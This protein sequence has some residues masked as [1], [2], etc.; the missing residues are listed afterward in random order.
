MEPWI[1]GKLLPLEVRMKKRAILGAV[2]MAIGCLTGASAQGTQPEWSR[3]EEETIRH[4]QALLRLDT[5]SPPGNESRAADYLKQVLESAGIPV[6]TFVL[7]PGRANLVARL[8]G[9]G[10]KRPLL[11]MAHTD[12]VTVDATKWTFPPFA[13]ARDG[14]YVYGRGALDDKDNLVASLMVMLLLKRQNVPLDRDVIFLAE[15]GEEGGSNVGINFMVERHFPEIDAEYC[16]AEGGDVRR[17]GGKL[18]FAGVQALEKHARTVELTARGLAGHASVPLETNPIAR[19]SAAV[20]AIAAWQAPIRLNEITSSYFR[21]LADISPPDRAAR[22]RAV[23]A[24]D[25]KEANAALGYFLKNEP[26]H[27]SILHTSV[28]PTII[29]GGYRVNVIP[30]EAKATL[31]VRMVPDE[32]PDRFLDVLR[33]VV[34]D[35]AVA[36][37]YGPRVDR[38]RTRVGAKLDSEAFK[39]IESAITTRYETVTIP[40]MSTGGTDMAQLRAKGMQCLGIAPATDVEDEAKGFGAHSD[41]ERILESELHRFVRFNWDVVSDL[42]RAR[43]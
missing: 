26:H 9:N 27:A 28:S 5:S 2:L 17:I 32:D 35:P 20:A 22:Y 8:T 13:G 30:S 7:E 18:T 10:R 12:V 21:R 24:A 37:G 4:F 39:A 34:N 33:T 41:Q 43:N 40:T 19:L 6:R 16:L 38:P 25:S 11:V 3:V 42:A 1:F 23:L 14:G 36:V 15:A 31:D 29:G